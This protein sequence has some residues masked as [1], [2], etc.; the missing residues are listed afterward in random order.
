M[1]NGFKF[2]KLKAKKESMK[3]WEKE[4]WRNLSRQKSKDYD[5]IGVLL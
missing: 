2:M 5:L 3:T 1:K 4:L